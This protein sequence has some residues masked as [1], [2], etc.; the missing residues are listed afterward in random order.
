MTL[1]PKNLGPEDRTA[2]IRLVLTLADSK[3]LMGIRYSDWLLGAPSVETGIATSSMA[4]DE[5]GHARLLYAM[6]KELDV[7]PEPIEHDRQASEYAS[8]AALDEEAPDWAALVAMMALADAAIATVLGSFAEGAF[9][10]ARSRVPKMLAEERFHASLAAAWFR[11]LAASEGEARP[12]LERAV[13]RMLPGLLAW[14][15][16]DD[17]SARRLVD[18]GVIASADERLTVFRDGVRD[19]LAEIDVDVDAVEPDADWDVERGRTGGQPAEEAV[20][21]ARGDLNRALFVE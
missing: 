6:L 2:L 4:Q 3:R 8:V 1:D 21:R 20:A 10:T 12:L 14:A 18:A 15:G 9:E 5:W 19:L 16:A 13:E 7:D 17:E 11:R